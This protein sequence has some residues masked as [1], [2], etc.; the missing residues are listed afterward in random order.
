MK[1]EHL[2]ADC[3]TRDNPGRRQGNPRLMSGSDALLRPQGAAKTES[4]SH[5]DIDLGESARD[6]RGSVLSMNSLI[7][8]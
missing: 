6:V 2:H 5:R 7:A 4:P 1:D 8:P 3:L